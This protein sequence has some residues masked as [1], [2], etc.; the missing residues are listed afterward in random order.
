M[1]STS[2]QH[3]GGGAVHRAVGLGGGAMV[4]GILY[5]PAWFPE[6]AGQGVRDLSIWVA[7]PCTIFALIPAIFI[8]S[9]STS[10]G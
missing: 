6:G 8:K 1:I 9:K 7:I 10:I 3:H 2:D 4:L 5:D